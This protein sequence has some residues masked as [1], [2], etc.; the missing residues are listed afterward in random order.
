ML[1]LSVGF[2]SGVSQYSP[3]TILGEDGYL[4]YINPDTTVFPNTEDLRP[5]FRRHSS[6]GQSFNI[7]VTLRSIVGESGGEWVVKDNNPTE[8]L[9]HTVEWE[10][11]GDAIE[12][13]DFIS[14]TPKTL[15]F[16]R[17]NIEQYINIQLLPRSGWFKEKR[18]DIRL[19]NPTADPEGDD[20]FILDPGLPTADFTGGVEAPILI[21]GGGDQVV[22]LVHPDANNEPPVISM[23]LDGSRIEDHG[24]QIKATFNLSYTPI[25][26]VTLY[27]KVTG[28]LEPYMV[29]P[30]SGTQKI[31]AGQTSKTITFTYQ[32][33]GDA[34]PQYSYF[35][36]S[37]DHERDTRHYRSDLL[38]PNDSLRRIEH[39]RHIDENIAPDSNGW[40]IK[41]FETDDYALNESRTVVDI[42]GEPTQW[43]I[44]GTDADPGHEPGKFYDQLADVKKKD[45]VTG[46]IL[47][48]LG[49]DETAA[50]YGDLITAFH[51]LKGGGPWQL[52]PLRNYVRHSMHIDFMEGADAERNFE[53]HEIAWRNRVK[54][55]QHSVT[56]R[57]NFKYNGVGFDGTPGI[58]ENG[59]TVPVY[60]IDYNGTE[61]KFWK[62]RTANIDGNTKY[63]VFKDDY[64]IC[65]WISTHVDSS[66]VWPDGIAISPTYP[67]GTPNGFVA[68]TD[69]PLKDITG[70]Q[71][72]VLDNVSDPTISTWNGVARTKEDLININA[73]VLVHSFMREMRD[74][75]FETDEPV[76][77]PR[78]GARWTP[79]GNATKSGL[80]D[81]IERVVKRTITG[82]ISGTKKYAQDLEAKAKQALVD[83]TEN[84]R[85]GISFP[86]GADG[87][88]FS[89]SSGNAL[90]RNQIT[91]LFFTA[92]GER[93]M[94]PDFGLDLKKYLF[95]Q[96][97]DLLI[98]SM[99]KEI[100]DQFRLYIPNAELLDLRVI[101]VE[102]DNSNQSLKVA[103]Q[104]IDKKTSEVIPLEFKI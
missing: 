54:L 69:Q 92:P 70:W 25:E 38:D 85:Q 41:G 17:D 10:N 9:V 58:D 4:S 30:E 55:I 100:Q 67:D 98:E 24:D 1:D 68:K 21:R 72:K 15:Q 8:G 91:Q 73:G 29:Y 31:I 51:D 19:V 44:G 40:D 43:I 2:L 79:R 23:E 26:D 96:L 90:I 11:V 59:N 78:L 88:L 89:K 50:G 74:T 18:I 14:T 71:C 16:S 7:L 3:V 64:G 63:G 36:I 46:H 45:P 62:W 27:Y 104:V 76:Y 80:I 101:P 77:W 6:P 5:H 53:C 35:Q 86:V 84:T 66:T 34:A 97:D 37:L 75:P 56:F 95:E 32:D 12:G 82:T 13:V 61:V 102:G 93:V 99:T 28:D 22:I 65:L 81:N 42:D 103:I 60:T 87:S 39:Y 57:N 33:E 94:I 83:T 47:K 48:V 20:T 52:E 49:A